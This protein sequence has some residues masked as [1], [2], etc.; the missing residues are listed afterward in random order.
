MVLE[1]SIEIGNL[2]HL[3]F[4]GGSGTGKTSTV[5]A[6]AMQLYGPN[7]INQKVLE[8]RRGVGVHFFRFD[9]A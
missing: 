6:L 7:K 5:L 2:P 3:L 8:E 1:K 4:H 9:Q